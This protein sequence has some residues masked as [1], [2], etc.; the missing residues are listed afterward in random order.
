M[1]GGTVTSFGGMAPTQV[2][3]IS[4]TF[5][6]EQARVDGPCAWAQHG[7]TRGHDQQEDVK[8]DILARSRIAR[9]HDP[10]LVESS[11]G[12]HYRRPQTSKQKDAACGGDQVL[13]HA[14]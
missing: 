1:V 7:H 10:G 9:E 6:A 11:E 5:P 14:D 2:R 4:K 12:S 3:S 13:G 8:P